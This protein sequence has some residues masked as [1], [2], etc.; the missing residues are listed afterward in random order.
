LLAHSSCVTFA[1]MDQVRNP[2]AT[3]KEVEERIDATIDMLARC[4]HKSQIK[5]G[6]RELVRR[7]TGV[8]KD[9]C[10]RECER[11]ISRAKDK[12]LAKAAAPR[13]DMIAESRAVY[14]AIIRDPKVA[15]S[16]KV[17]ARERM[18]LLQGLDAPKRQE[19]TGADG[20]P[21]M[22]AGAEE[23]LRVVYGERA[24]APV[25]PAENGNGEHRNG[26]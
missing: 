15:A 19:I 25:A 9:L 6:L 18:D 26:G 10:G 17:R 16:V 21:L 20:Q 24:L 12:I 23:A 22:P 11:Y 5:T 7:Q 3:Q 8:D 14:E 2:K 4:W 13:D 1:A